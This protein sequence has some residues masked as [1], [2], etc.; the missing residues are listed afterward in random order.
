M[1]VDGTRTMNTVKIF[2]SGNSQAVRLPR[3]FQPEGTEVYVK[4]VGRGLLLMP[5]D[6]PW[7]SLASGLDNFREDFM[8]ERAQ[9]PLELLR[10]G[11]DQVRGEV[12]S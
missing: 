5:K 12:L 8:G 7:A 11:A 10:P 1:Q 3:G 4:K 9:P 6:D 2:K